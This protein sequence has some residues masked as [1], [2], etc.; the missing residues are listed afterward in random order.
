MQKFNEKKCI[1]GNRSRKKNHSFPRV[2]T[3]AH[4]MTIITSATI[5]ERATDKFYTRNTKDISMCLPHLHS[6]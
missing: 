5:C 4:Q 6:Q 3:S 1:D 2:F